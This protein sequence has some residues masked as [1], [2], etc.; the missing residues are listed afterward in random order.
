MCSESISFFTILP[1]NGILSYPLNSP[2]ILFISQTQLNDLSVIGDSNQ[3]K[4][5][6]KV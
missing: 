2:Q 1:S 6:N 5:T 4:Q 3:V